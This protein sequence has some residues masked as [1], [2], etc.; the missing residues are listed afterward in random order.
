MLLF[1]F[2]AEFTEVFDFELTW[3]VPFRFTV[4]WDEGA[5]HVRTHLYCNGI[6]RENNECPLF[7]LAAIHKMLFQS[8]VGL[9]TV[10][11]PSATWELGGVNA[12]HKK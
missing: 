11:L 2:V 8:L 3:Q 7:L 12:D 6:F 5:N 4:I 10:Q 1:R 9:R